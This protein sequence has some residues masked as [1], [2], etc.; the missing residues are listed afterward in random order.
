[1]KKTYPNYK[2]GLFVLAPLIGI[3]PTLPPP[4]GGAL[5]LSY[6]GKFN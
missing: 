5:P 1:M 3:E 6:K 4:E 2:I